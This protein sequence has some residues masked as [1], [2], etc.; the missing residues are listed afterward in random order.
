MEYPTT[1][2]QKTTLSVR[3][4]VLEGLNTILEP[5]GEIPLFNPALYSDADMPTA[6]GSMDAGDSRQKVFEI[7]VFFFVLLL[8]F[9]CLF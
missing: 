5:T 6:G 8:C 9:A 7:L 3:E 2:T 4:K 1:R